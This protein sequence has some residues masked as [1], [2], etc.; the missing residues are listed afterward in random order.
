MSELSTVLLLAAVSLPTND[1][2]IEPWT[3]QAAAGVA[4][5]V[6]NLA[7]W[8]HSA[9]GWS[10]VKVRQ[11]MQAAASLGKWLMHYVACLLHLLFLSCKGA[12]KG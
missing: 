3:M 12:S 4:L 8:L 7:D 6:G 5:L 9:K 2:T 10:L 1:L 11:A